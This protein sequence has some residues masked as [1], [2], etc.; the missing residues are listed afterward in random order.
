MLTKMDGNPPS[1]ESAASILIRHGREAKE[2]LLNSLES[3]YR[4]WA[5]QRALLAQYHECIE[6]AD[7]LRDIKRP[8]SAS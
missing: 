7:K 2:Q 3:G 8:A 5:K 1:A 6:A 4:D